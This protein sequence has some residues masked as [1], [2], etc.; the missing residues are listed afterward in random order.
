MWTKFQNTPGKSIVR[1]SAVAIVAIATLST[2][3]V[4]AAI[5]SYRAFLYG[6]NEVPVSADPDGFGVATVSIDNVANTVSWAIRTINI[7][8]PLTGA[9]IHQGAAGVNGPVKID[10][11]GQLTGSNL[12]DPDLALVT[13]GTASGFY[14]NLHN[15]VYPRGAIRGQLQYVG[16]A[17]VVP[18]PETYALLIAGLGAVG[19]MAKR[20]RRS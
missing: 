5:D 11:S 10:F 4:N 20:R 19:L 18:E 16:T 2:S 15:A 8:T 9:H 6:V 3:A 12:A 17:N 1:K 7:V 13:P 14:V